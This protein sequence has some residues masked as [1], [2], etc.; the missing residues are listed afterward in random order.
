[1][2]NLSPV[3]LRWRESVSLGRFQNCKLLE[4][5]NFRNHG[6]EDESNFISICNLSARAQ[7]GPDNAKNT[8]QSV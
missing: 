1:M 5:D 3:Q 8:G 6:V 2:L 4:M 7:I